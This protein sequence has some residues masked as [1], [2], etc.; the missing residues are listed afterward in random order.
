MAIRSPRRPG[1]TLTVAPKPTE[2]QRRSLQNRRDLA[3]TTFF[4][5]IVGMGGLLV[6]SL[7][8]ASVRAGLD[9]MLV[10]LACLAVGSLVGFLFGIPRVLQGDVPQPA[11]AG[12]GREEED[13]GPARPAVYRLHVNTNLEQISDWLTKIIVGVGL[14]ELRR[15]PE[16]L[17]DASAFVARA[18]G[19]G[20]DAQTVAA[21]LI[22]YFVCIGF[23][24]GYLLTRLFLAAAFSRA[25]QETQS[26]QELE[27]ESRQS[28]EMIGDLLHQ[29]GK[30]IPEGSPDVMASMPTT[31]VRR[32]LWV[33]DQPQNNIIM[34]K[35]LQDRGIEVVLSPST[36]DALRKLKDGL[37]DRIISDMGR[38]EEGR[39][40]DTAGI[41]LVK[42][43]HAA[44]LDVPV[45][46]HC[47]GAAAARF[48]DQALQAGAKVV[49]PSRTVL[50]KALE[51][52]APPAQNPATPAR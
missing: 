40:N 51:L 39:Y 50:L 43:V 18:V 1:R 8:R 28:R 6:A 5:A 24:G 22:V 2:E 13:G 37:F 42:A 12:E 21:V 45:A 41:D 25:D 32:I 48:G 52:D 10:S 46:I 16:L 14:I 36:E 27:E 47:S 29:V 3:V 7:G 49:T 33:D 38:E 4:F 17:R 19:A 20:P 26:Y 30:M 34:V 11:P 31:T 44:G 9:A 35:V 23:L 15:M